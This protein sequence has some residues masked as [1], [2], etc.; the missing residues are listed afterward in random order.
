LSAGDLG[1]SALLVV[2]A[3]IVSVAFSLRVERQLAIAACRTVI[4]L[5]LIG[6][7]LRIVFEMESALALVP[8]VLM[9]VGAAS[10]AAVG[11]LSRSFPGAAVQAFFTLT[12]CG[13]L[14][15]LLVTGAIINVKPWYQPRYLV[16]LLGMVLGNALTGVSLCLDSLLERLDRGRAEV[17]A[18]LALGATRWEAARDHVREGVRRG[19]IPIVNAMMVVGLVSLPGM[20]TG[21]ILAGEDPFEAVK[22]QIVVM[23]MIA[24]GTAMACSLGALFAYRRLFTFE[25]RLKS[26]LIRPARRRA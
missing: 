6:Y 11:R 13:V 18:D 1:V 17:E 5:L 9:M 23:F 3:G 22:Y 4:Q 14:T 20:M 21:Q 7:V 16:P 8:V 10:L 26:D 24:G 25:H 12:L 2:V 15:T 19:L